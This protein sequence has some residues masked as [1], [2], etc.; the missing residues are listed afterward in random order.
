M[1]PHDR[2]GG[3]SNVHRG[4]LRRYKPY[5]LR[6]YCSYTLGGAVLP[7]RTSH[8]RFSLLQEG[9]QPLLGSP[10]LVV[11]AH[12]QDDV[13]PVK[14]AHQ[15]EPNMGL[16]GIRGDCAQERQMDALR[17]AEQEKEITLLTFG[18]LRVFTNTM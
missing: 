1:W 17:S 12:Y 7:T 18:I 14:L 9:L 6:R 3:N 5:A 13:V 16:V 10:S 2:R 11:V 15:V 4:P 8:L